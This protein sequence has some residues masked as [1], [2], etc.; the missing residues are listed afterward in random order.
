MVPFETTESVTATSRPNAVQPTIRPM[1]TTLR[2]SSH[3]APSRH[4]RLGSMSVSRSGGPNRP[5]S[6]PMPSSAGVPKSTGPIP[7]GRKVGGCP[8][9]WALW[10]WWPRSSSSQ[11]PRWS[12]SR[13][14]RRP[15]TPRGPRT[16]ARPPPTRS[17]MSIEK[18]TRVTFRRRT[19]SCPHGHGFVRVE[20]PD[21]KSRADEAVPRSPSCHSRRFRRHASPRPGRTVGCIS[22]TPERL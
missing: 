9:S 20:R 13:C 22:L 2:Q 21:P 5:D 18:Q 12:W 1:S 11:K 3:P 8:S 15:H 10:S 16:S 7:S 6:T 4:S 17:A 14:R 19:S